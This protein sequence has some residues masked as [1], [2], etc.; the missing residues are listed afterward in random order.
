MI[1]QLV[2]RIIASG[3]QPHLA[4][5]MVLEADPFDLALHLEQVWRA[6]HP[7]APP[8]G[9]ARAQLWSTGA[10]AVYAPTV[11]QAWDHLAYSYVLENTRAAQIMRRVVRQY[12][13]GESIGVPTPETQRWLDTTEALLFGAANPVAPWLSTSSLRQDPE[14][15]RRNAYW[16]FFGLD[17]A[18]GTEDNRAPSF[19][20]AAAANTN[21]VA[22]FEELLFELWK[23][24]SN[25]RNT[26]GENAADNDRIF[27][28]AEALHFELASRR[29]SHMLTRE[30]LA[31]ATALGWLELTLSGNSPV[32]ENLRATGTSPSE[33]LKLIGERVGLPAHSRSGSLFSMAADLSRFLRIVE[34]NV[35]RGP[36]TAWI[37][38]LEQAP[39]GTTQAPIGA[40]SRRV[41]TEWAA[42]TGKDLKVR[43]KPVEIARPKL[44]AV[45]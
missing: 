1:Q 44:V 45:R 11:W 19:E 35:V 3:V 8:A 41:I 17:L 22:I 37:L 36:E 38:Y 10:F 32:V 13:S 42:A 25:L 4:A 33:R 28:L 12:R 20:K 27:R 31:A 2:Q 34:S 9:T 26:S 15:V 16:R 43:G 18:F 24:M 7:W 30:E 23:A 39:P 21:F 14:C 6:A 5:Q 29:Q 40:S